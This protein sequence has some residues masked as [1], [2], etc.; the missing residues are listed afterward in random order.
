VTKTL[1]FYSIRSLAAQSPLTKS[2]NVLINVLTPGMTLSDLGQDRDTPLNATLR[3]VQ[4]LLLSLIARQTHVGAR[5]LIHAVEP[6]L[7]HAA[8]GKFL[9]DSQIVE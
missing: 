1:L 9:M 6:D 3:K 8:H 2:S 5:T 7:N 4:R